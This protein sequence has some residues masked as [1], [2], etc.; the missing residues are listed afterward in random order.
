VSRS[1]VQLSLVL[2]AAAVGCGSGSGAAV[3]TATG[4]LTAVQHRQ[5][6][7]AC[8]LMAAG[9]ADRL[10]R[11]YAPSLIGQPCPDIV[12]AYRERLSDRKLKAI[13][14]GGGLEAAD[15]RTKD[16]RLGIFP[17]AKAY[18]LDVILMGRSGD[19]WRVLSAAVEPD[20]K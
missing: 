13:L 18:D 19:A 11:K 5:A 17:H 15:A 20:R 1:A 8:R 9:A 4:W 12:L 3:E 14:S 2:A 7:T 10:A 6:P 16:G